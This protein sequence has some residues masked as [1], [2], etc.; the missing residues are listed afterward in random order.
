MKRIA[1]VC[2]VL[3]LAAAASACAGGLFSE[4]E[5]E[6]PPTAKE[7]V[8]FSN[9]PDRTIGQGLLE[10]TLID[11]YMKENPDVRITVRTIAPDTQFRSKIKLLQA[12]REM[13]DM[14]VSWGDSTFLD[15]L[16]Q[17]GEVYAFNTAMLAEYG[18]ESGALEPFTREGR[19]YG[20]PRNHHFLVLYYNRELFEK[21]GVAVPVTEEE[22]LASGKI[23]QSHGIIPVAAN[24]RGS[25]LFKMLFNAMV[26]RVSG[27]NET[28]AD[29]NEGRIAYMDSPILSA[30]AHMQQWVKEGLFGTSVMN[31]DYGAA[32][33][34]FGQGQAAMYLQS[35]WEADMDKDR[36]FKADTRAAMGAVN[37]PVLSSGKGTANDVYSWYGEGISVSK[38]S[39]VLEEALSFAKWMFRPDN[40]V[41]L[42]ADSGQALPLQ[43]LPVRHEPAKEGLSAD[44]AE[45]WT[46][47]S[48]GAPPV[49]TAERMTELEVARNELIGRFVSLQ[50]SPEQFVYELDRLGWDISAIRRYSQNP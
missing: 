45:I 4:S 2:V 6:V 31:Q 14:F 15:P 28:L 38:N 42:A 22:L 40:W 32:R 12:S 35:N 20:L 43:Q 1:A 17:S 19:V 5:G 9:K 25:D 16:I 49:W 7:I 36:S 13:P 18:F 3:L 10:Q 8:F 11:R 50:L 47:G 21:F 29:A 44:L 48:S 26:Q 24:G 46:K 34:L 30:A 39:P 41:A 23:F 27:T 33:T 37:L